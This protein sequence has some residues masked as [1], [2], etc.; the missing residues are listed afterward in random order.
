M[1]DSQDLQ[2]QINELCTYVS[3]LSLLGHPLD[4]KMFAVAIILSLPPSYSTLQTIISATSGDR[5]NSQE[6]ISTILTKEQWRHKTGDK[7]LKAHTRKN[8]KL[9]KPKGD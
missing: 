8:S 4:D 9:N 3:R 5:L 7:A 6:V 2:M 1:S